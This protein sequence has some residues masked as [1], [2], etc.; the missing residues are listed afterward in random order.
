V[1]LPKSAV[2]GAVTAVTEGVCPGRSP[3][4]TRVCRFARSSSAVSGAA[5]AAFS[6][7]ETWTRPSPETSASPRHTPECQAV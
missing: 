5:P 2:V 3:A 7:T 1:N 6:S 4:K